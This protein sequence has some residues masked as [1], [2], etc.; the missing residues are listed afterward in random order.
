MSDELEK[1]WTKLQEVITR[2][3][4]E[5]NLR[6]LK[7]VKLYLHEMYLINSHLKYPKTQSPS[8]YSKHHSKNPVMNLPHDP[9]TNS[10]TVTNALYVLQR[11][12]K[13]RIVRNI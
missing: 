4:A 8:S 10:W 6:N 1:I 11:L 2:A 5:A 13:C 3:D 12:T 9:G 7:Y